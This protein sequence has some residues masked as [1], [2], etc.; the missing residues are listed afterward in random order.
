MGLH[1][2]MILGIAQKYI[3]KPSEIRKWV[4]RGIAFLTAGYGIYAFAKRDIGNYMLLKNQFVF[5]NFEEPLILFL[6]DY[7]AVMGVFIFV[8][9]YL[10]KVIRT[11]K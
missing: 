9:Y 6:I 8:G 10:S 2:S 11:V 4:L 7:A 1:W 3:V 5:F